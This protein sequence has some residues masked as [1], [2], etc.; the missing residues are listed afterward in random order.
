MG[1]L[2]LGNNFKSKISYFPP[3]LQI[4]SFRGYYANS[5]VLP[6]LPPSLHS[7][8][9]PTS[10]LNGADLRLFSNLVCLCIGNL[11]NLVKDEVVL[12]PPT[13]R[14]LAVGLIDVQV[15]LP[16][17]LEFLRAENATHCIMA[18]SVKHLELFS[19]TQ[20]V[21]NCMPRSITTLY[22][23]R[24]FIQ[25]LDNL[26]NSLS[27]LTFN[28][29]SEFNN[30]FQCPPCITELTLNNAFD[31]PFFIPS[32][33]KRLTFGSYFNSQLDVRKSPPLE[34]E[35]LRFGAY[36]RKPI[37]VYFPNLR[38]LCFGVS[39][40]NKIQYFP[41][42]LEKLTVGASFCRALRKL[43]D[44]L[45]HL[46]IG[47]RYVRTDKLRI[48]DILSHKLP[49]LLLCVTFINLGGKETKLNMEEIKELISDARKR[50]NDA[51]SSDESET[52]KK[53]KAAKRNRLC[54]ALL[55]CAMVAPIVLSIM[56]AFATKQYV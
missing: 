2:R 19:A 32:S 12:L 45:T 53:D 46:T 1:Y 14:N 20:Q 49:P 15:E 48:Q 17:S 35:Y 22:L 50:D 5:T 9:L 25:F 54:Q 16:Q 30:K 42:R 52:D 47:V 44:T 41:P 37:S 13:L 21:T 18:P 40:N 7:L 51:S 31:Q 56:F 3:K 39:F 38:E 10:P 33:L 55:I 4:L 6:P 29:H 28:P 26:P 24:S 43:P 23:G 8:V 34:L 11:S 27:V 36:Y